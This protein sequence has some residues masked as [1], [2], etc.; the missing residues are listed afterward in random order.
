M[1]E[2]A[3]G[4]CG[5]DGAVTFDPPLPERTRG[6]IDRLG[7]GDFLKAALRFPSDVWP[8]GLDW[9]GRIGEP[10][11][12]EFVDLRAVAGES[13]AVGF[14]T[15]SEARR[16]EG[17][18]DDAVV[19]EA[20]AALG[21]A[22][23]ATLPDP[24]AAVVTRW[25]QDPFALGSYSFLGVDATPDDRDVLAEPLDARRILAGEA[26]NR[27]HPSTMHG[28]WLSGRAAADR[29]MGG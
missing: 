16:L 6:A 5:Q 25:A 14:A 18:S 7:M 9:L 22:L 17:L 13:I 20:V 8:G 27:R 12:N 15:G 21:A 23:G 26:T 10:T 3:Q 4:L 24:E 2:A 28:A 11:F 19:G 1:T 29:V